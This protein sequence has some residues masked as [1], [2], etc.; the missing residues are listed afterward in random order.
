MEPG[1]LA[2]DRSH[3]DTALRRLL[4][5]A[6]Q[7][8]GAGSG[9]TGK[10]RVDKGLA[11]GVWVCGRCRATQS[12]RQRE[13]RE[14]SNQY[15]LHWDPPLRGWGNP[16][17]YRVPAAC[18]IAQRSVSRRSGASMQAATPAHRLCAIAL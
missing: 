9:L 1:E 14:H 2:Q 13:R 12:E 11:A 8:R 10:A 18:N 3:W 16:A 15:P 7:F 17:Y 4:K 6:L 5:G